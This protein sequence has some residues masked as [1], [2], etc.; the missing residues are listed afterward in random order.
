VKRQVEAAFTA[1]P[2]DTSSSKAP[3][4]PPIKARDKLIID[5]KMVDFANSVTADDEIQDLPC[6]P[7][8]P[9]DV[10]RGYLRG[11]GTLKTVLRQIFRET[12]GGKEYEAAHGMENGVDD[13]DGNEDGGYVST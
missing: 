9:D 6:P 3:T 1:E 13:D 5:L 2:V 11:L 10:D 4:K 7:H 12:N 8:Y